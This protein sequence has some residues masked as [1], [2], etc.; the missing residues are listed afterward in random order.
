MLD[1]N[2]H[3]KKQKSKFHAICAPLLAHILGKAGACARF[4]LV[5]I[6][7]RPCLAAAFTLCQLDPAGVDFRI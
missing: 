7:H 3:M 4:A 2:T 1:A 6:A 5:I